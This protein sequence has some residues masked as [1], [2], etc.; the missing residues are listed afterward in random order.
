MSISFA[1]GLSCANNPQ[2]NITRSPSAFIDGSLTIYKA[3]HENKTWTVDP[4]SNP[5]KRQESCK[6]C[7]ARIRN[8]W[9]SSPQGNC[10]SGSRGLLTLSASFS[11]MDV[12]CVQT[13]QSRPSEKKKTLYVNINSDNL[14]ANSDLEFARLTIPAF[15]G[16]L[17][18]RLE[19][20][21]YLH[22]YRSRSG[23]VCTNKT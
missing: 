4:T 20:K 2:R 11:L 10:S 16:S 3:G 22:S 23:I 1:A 14:C 6:V 17:Y 8:T 13:T 18:S 12:R 21:C 5:H 7:S 15:V 19:S 9:T